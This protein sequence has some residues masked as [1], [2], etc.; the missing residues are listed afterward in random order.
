MT[1][2]F[3]ECLVSMYKLNLHSDIVRYLRENIFNKEGSGVL[4]VIFQKTPCPDGAIIQKNSIEMQVSYKTIK[5]WVYRCRKKENNSFK[6][7]IFPNI[8]TY[9]LQFT[10]STVH[11]LAQMFN[12]MVSEN[13]LCKM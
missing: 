13:F 5:Q 8:L 12:P 10:H 9:P 11:S 3:Y 6:C 1:H 7:A 2:C 4:V